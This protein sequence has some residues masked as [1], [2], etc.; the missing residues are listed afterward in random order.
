MKE[1][2]EE[3]CSLLWCGFQTQLV[4]LGGKHL[5]PLSNIASP[6]PGFFPTWVLG[7]QSR[8]LLLWRQAPHWLSHLAPY[9]LFLSSAWGSSGPL[10]FV[11]ALCS[12]AWPSEAMASVW[13]LAKILRV[14]RT[15]WLRYPPFF[16]FFWGPGLWE[17]DVENWN[18][19]CPPIPHLLEHS[20]LES[21]PKFRA[22]CRPQCLGSLCFLK[23]CCL[24]LSQSLPFPCP[25]AL[26]RPLESSGVPSSASGV[27][28]WM[29]SPWW[30][31]STWRLLFSLWS[32]FFPVWVNVYM[33]V[34]VSMPGWVCIDTCS[35]GHVEV[36]GQGQLPSSV[37]LST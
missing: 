35:H 18:Y 36:R 37:A 6:C 24:P 17:Q 25:G 10:L 28:K 1:Q 29:S 8:V 33:C 26:L 32:L 21:S 19:P 7:D 14:T 31:R 2:L 34:G 27:G 16:S 15:V 4:R 30:L 9:C 3:V 20:F 5:Y 22:E 11:P 13:T 23:L 12:L